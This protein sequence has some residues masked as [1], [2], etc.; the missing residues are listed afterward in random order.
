MRHEPVHSEHC[1]VSAAERQRPE[2]SVFFLARLARPEL[3]LSRRAWILTGEARVLDGCTYVCRAHRSSSGRVAECLG[4]RPTECPARHSG[5]I[6]TSTKAQA[7][8]ASDSAAVGLVPIALAGFSRARGTLVVQVAFTNVTNTK[9]TKNGR[10][11]GTA[12][13]ARR[14]RYS[15]ADTRRRVHGL[16]RGPCHRLALR[17][18]WRCA[19]V[20]AAAAE[21]RVEAAGASRAR[22]RAAERR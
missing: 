3:L 5:R 14:R 10:A 22:G 6:R 2:D 18:P 11:R 13:R 4:F 9:Q 20:G 17:G 7:R 8:L 21:G 15:S 16:D 1:V 19:W 12:A